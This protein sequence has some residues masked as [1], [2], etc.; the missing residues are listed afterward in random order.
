MPAVFLHP[1]RVHEDEIDVLGHANNLAYLKW[2]LAAALAHSDVQGW[3][4]DRYH[5]L[6]AR[7]GRSFAY[8]QICCGARRCRA[9]RSWFALGWP[10]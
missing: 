4:A 2:M 9:R 7:M 1:H 6:G 5:T 3:P 8:D 10:I